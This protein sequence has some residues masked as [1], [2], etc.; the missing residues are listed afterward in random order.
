M[1][2]NQHTHWHSTGPSDRK[3]AVGDTSD[4]EL[5]LVDIATGRKKLLSSGHRPPGVQPHAH[6]SMSPDGK[7]VLFCSGRLGSSDLMT[8]ALPAFDTLKDHLARK[9]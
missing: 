1:I 4:G 5:Y 3:Y 6:Q 8:I 7:R 9:K 2:H